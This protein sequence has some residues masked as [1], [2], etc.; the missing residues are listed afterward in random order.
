MTHDNSAA[1]ALPYPPEHARGSANHAH[2]ASRWEA[3]HTT[4]S[5]VWR[6]LRATHAGTAITHDHRTRRRYD[7]ETD[8]VHGVVLV[9]LVLVIV[10]NHFLFLRL[11][12]SYVG[13]YIR[14]GA[15]IGLVTTMLAIVWDQLDRT[16]P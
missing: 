14:N 13:W 16:W 10:A 7:R 1:N 5:A 4:Q 2:A 6:T 8:A 11:G 3:L 15:L 9:I 12:H